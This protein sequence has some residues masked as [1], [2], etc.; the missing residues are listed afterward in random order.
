MFTCLKV[1]DKQNGLIYTKGTKEKIKK[2]GATMATYRKADVG[3]NYSYYLFTEPTKAGERLEA[4]MV[5]N[6]GN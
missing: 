2:G 4:G 1:L 6:E 3:E 5:R